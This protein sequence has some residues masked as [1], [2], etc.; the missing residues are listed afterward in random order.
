M[1]FDLIA[2]RI[3]LTHTAAGDI[4]TQLPGVSLQYCKRPQVLETF[5]SYASGL[6]TLKGEETVGKKKSELVGYV[7]DTQC[8]NSSRIGHS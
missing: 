4:A 2:V 8:L 3:P 6:F 5:P 7:R 1:N